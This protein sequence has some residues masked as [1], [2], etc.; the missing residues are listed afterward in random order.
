MKQALLSR[1]HGANDGK[2]ADQTN[3]SGEEN[4]SREKYTR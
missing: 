1:F 4:E 2:Q 3:P